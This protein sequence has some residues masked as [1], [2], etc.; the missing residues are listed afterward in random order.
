MNGN[1]LMR[2]ETLGAKIPPPRD[3]D[4]Y[5]HTLAVDFRR[6]DAETLRKYCA[7]FGLDPSSLPFPELACVVAKHFQERKSHQEE[8]AILRHFVEFVFSYSGGNTLEEMKTKAGKR[9]R[10]KSKRLAGGNEDAVSAGEESDSAAASLAAVVAAEEPHV[11]CLCN[12]TSYGAMIGCD[13]TNCKSGEW[14]HLP[15]V[16]LKDGD[17]KLGKEW[18]CPSCAKKMAAEGAVAAAAGGRNRKRQASSSRR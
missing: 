5:P 14:F 10:K 11:Y 17:E 16:G 6:C 4:R 7:R 15:C 12:R 18:F 9:L 13:S 2:G 3:V 8:T 1:A